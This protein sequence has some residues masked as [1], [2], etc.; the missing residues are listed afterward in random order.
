MEPCPAT[1]N[2][3]PPLTGLKAL[4]RLRTPFAHL[5]DHACARDRA[6]NRALHLDQLACPVVVALFNP[7]ARS[8]RAPSRISDLKRVRKRFGVTH[9]SI[10]SPS[11]AAR[12]SDPELIAQVIGELTA[13]PADGIRDPRLAAIKSPPS[14]VDGT[15]LKAMP[16]LL[17]SYHETT[18]NGSHHHA[19]RLH[20]H[21]D[22][23]SP[24]P[25]RV[26]LTGPRNSGEADEKA[27]MRRRLEAG[28]TYVMDRW[29]AQFTHLN[30]I[31][32]AGGD[33]ACRLRDNTAPQLVESR[34]L[35]P[36]ATAAGVLR[37]PIVRLGESSGV[38]KR[39]DRATRPATIR[40]Q[41]HRKRG[42]RPGQAAGPPSPASSCWR[43][44]CS[45]C[46]RRS[47]GWS[48]ST[49]GPSRSSSGHSSRC[50]AAGTCPGSIPG[51]SCWRRT[52]RSWRAC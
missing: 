11:E 12:L 28:R 14:A 22:I 31:V 40:I 26:D 5:H 48:T 23:D 13:S 30:A 9:A 4:G 19:W 33:Y 51:G 16:I 27:V 42:G 24:I 2:A 20:C 29:L 17:A 32:A 8:L 1:D 44:T 43:P 15:L 46:R 6:G 39:P 37:D 50:W 21:L 38:E 3:P 47:S 34:L 25:R 36:E 52:V 45:T 18:S 41:P 35:T 7:A 49:A 10:G